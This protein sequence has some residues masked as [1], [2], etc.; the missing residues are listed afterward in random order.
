M[1]LS[2]TSCF[3]LYSFTTVRTGASTAASTISQAVAQCPNAKISY[4]GYSKVSKQTNH[5][6]ADLSQVTRNFSLTYDLGF[7]LLFLHPTT[8]CTRCSLYSAIRCCPSQDGLYRFVRCKF[9]HL[10]T[11]MVALY[12]CV[13]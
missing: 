1:R 13:Y 7:G 10:Q 11:F 12:R 6:Q 4:S 8:G 9:R 5:Q 2:E 3:F